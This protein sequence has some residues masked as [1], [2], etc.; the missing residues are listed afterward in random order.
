M[1]D[2]PGLFHQARSGKSLL[3][4]ILQTL[5]TNILLQVVNI[6][7][8]VITARILAP[9]GRGDLTAIIMWPGFLSGL[10]TFGMQTSLI[11]QLRSGVEHLDEF[12]GTA[13]ALGFLSGITATTIGIIGIP[14]WLHGY[15]PDVVRFAQLAML[16]APLNLVGGL[17]YTSAQAVQ[18][19]SRFN[20]FRSLPN[21]IILFFLLLLAWVHKLTPQSGAAAYLLAGLP[22]VVWNGIWALRRFNLKFGTI[23][24]R[25]PQLLNYGVRAWGMD[26]VGS[27]SDQ[28]DRV[29]VVGFLSPSDL[30]LYVVAQSAARLFSIIPGALQL[31]MSPKIVLLGSKRGASLLVR[32]ARITFVT[33]SVVALPLA[34][35]ASYAI[36]M[37]Y[38]AKF[39]SATPVFRVLLAEAVVGG[40]TWLLAQGFSSLGTARTGDH[41]ANSWALSF[42]PIVN[43]L[44]AK[45]WDQRCL[46]RFAGLDNYPVD[47][48]YIKLSFSVWRKLDTIY[49]A[50]F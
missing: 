8:G 34:L 38:G 41:T 31:A 50:I 4:A 15:S 1:L 40:F 20:K 7:T 44:S 2:I 32:T 17:L 24:K 11:Y 12:V 29:L 9:H 33:M 5:S 23:F 10:L 45:I 6:L 43:F 36:R 16:V 27:I 3:G 14:F 21:L 46:L 35:F 39:T 37:V 28:V 49:T 48:C 26:L 22:V 47:F 30:G 25:A 42:R 13:L 19:F 18:E